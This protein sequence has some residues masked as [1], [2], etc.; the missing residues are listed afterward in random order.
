MPALVAPLEKQRKQ[1]VQARST[2]TVD[3]ILDAC[4]QVLVRVGKEKLTTTLVAAR[5][6]VSVGTL[7]QYFPNKR[8]LLQ[9]TL[10]LHLSHVSQLFVSACAANEGRPLCEMVTNVATIFFAAKMKRP[11]QGL[12]L[13]S[14]SADID[15]IRLTEDLRE[16]NAQAFEAMLRTSPE[17]L[18]VDAAQA[19]FILQST[20][21]GIS[22]LILEARMPASEHAAML[23]Q[24]LVML[25]GYLDGVRVAK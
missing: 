19:A 25:C 7:Y 14:V 8:S 13:Y 9:A 17:K 15:G 3:A 2:A 6:G 22:R 10:R 4:L 21:I 11:Q 5:A 12:A 1:P 24:L 16:R 20:M 23:E 18:K